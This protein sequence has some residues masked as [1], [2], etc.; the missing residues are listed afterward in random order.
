MKT[1]TKISLIK[2]EAGVGLFTLF[3][4]TPVREMASELRQPID[5]NLRR[6]CFSKFILHISEKC[7]T[8][9]GLFS[10]R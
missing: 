9:A 5:D 8:F 1:T 3:V 4:A 10:G 7:F 6:G 2:A